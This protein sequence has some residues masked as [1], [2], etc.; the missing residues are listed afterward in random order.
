MYSIRRKLSIIILVCSILATILTAL[1]VNFTINNKFNEYML[2]N[3]EKRNQRIVQYFQEIY[4]RDKQWTKES[5]MEME[6]E[7]FMSNYCLTL[8]D[9]N[10]KLIWTMD[11]NDIKEKEHLKAIDN[12]N[13]GVYNTTNFP[14]NYN[15]SV[16]GYIGIGQYS[17]VLLSADDINFKLS[18]NKGIGASIILT[19]IIVIVVSLYFSKQFSVPIREVSDISVKLS[20][21]DYNSRTNVDTDIL[22]LNNLKSSINTLGDRLNQQDILRRRLISDISHEIRTPLNVLQNNLEAMIDGIFPVNTEQLTALND[23]VIRFG[24]LLNN[25][26]VLKRFESEGIV[27]DEEKLQLNELIT[28]V[29]DDFLIVSKEKNIELTY[30]TKP[31]ESYVILG[32]KYK[33]RQVFVNILSNAVKFTN[34]GGSIWVN[35]AKKKNEIIVSIRDNGMGISKEDLPFIFERL[36]RGDKSRNKIEGSGIGLTIVKNILTLH[37]ASIDVESEVNKGSKFTIRFK[38]LK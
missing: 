17:S 20:K 35:L 12:A 23:E 6:H 27:L 36:Y 22:E 1:F 11:P 32:D 18:I 3:Q 29:C 34:E 15:G 38:S 9:A 8:L 4:K 25:L 10:K 5:G 19:L 14:I 33:L 7:A 37:S 26:N 21:G 2:N 16:V 24:K 13:E 30:N 28:S 31:N